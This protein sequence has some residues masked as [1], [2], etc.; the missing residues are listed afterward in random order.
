MEQTGDKPPESTRRGQPQMKILEAMSLIYEIALKK[1]E[2]G[3][4]T[5]SDFYR[6]LTRT[7]NDLQILRDDS[8]FLPVEVDLNDKFL[9]QMRRK[10]IEQLMAPPISA[11]REPWMR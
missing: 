3:I 4:E 10:R 1:E 11:P 6:M 7:Y 2:Y 8:I 5:S 9:K